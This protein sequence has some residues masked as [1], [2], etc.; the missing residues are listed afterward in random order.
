MD[1][2]CTSAVSFVG[3]EQTPGLVSVGNYQ[4]K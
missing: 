4:E 3:E 2:S 1:I